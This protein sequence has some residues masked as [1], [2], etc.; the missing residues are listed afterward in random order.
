ML[1]KGVR[2]EQEIKESVRGKKGI[3]IKRQYRR[4]LR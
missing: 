1:K 3:R 2:K 4:I